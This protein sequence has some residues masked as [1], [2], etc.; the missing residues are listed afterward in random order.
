MILLISKD[1]ENTTRQI[2]ILRALNYEVIHAHY[3]WEV[4]EFYKASNPIKLTLIDIDSVK[5]ASDFI[6]DILDIK[7]IPFIYLTAEIKSSEIE[8]F[9]NNCCYGCIPKDASSFVLGFSISNALSLFKATKALKANEKRYK[10]A[11]LLAGFGHWEMDLN[12]KI[13]FGSEGTE[14]IY[15]V[16][17]GPYQHAE[18]EN[19]VLPEFREK[20]SEAFRNMIQK[21][22]HYDVEFEIKNKK[23][24]NIVSIHSVAE[25]DP[26]SNLVSGSI[27]DISKQKTAEAI[28]KKSGEDY[29]NLFENHHAVM[30]IIDPDTADIVHANLAASKFYGW[31]QNELTSM[32]IT[33]INTLSKKEVYHEMQ[34]A[35]NKGKKYFLFKHRLSNGKV[36]DV[37]VYSGPVTFGGKKRFL[38]IIHD[39]TKRKEAEKA[40][41]RLAYYDP[42]TNLPNRK[43]FIKNL[44]KLISN[45]SKKNSK[46]SLLYIDLDNFKNINDNYG[47]NIGD[48]F[49]KRVVRRLKNALGE[50]S[51]IS[52]LGGDEFTI[53]LEEISDVKELSDIA[54]KILSTLK[55]PFKI[56]NKYNFISASIGISIFPDDGDSLKKLLNN[57]DTVM[58]QAKN[59]GKDCYCFFSEELNQVIKRKDDIKSELR[60]ALKNNELDLYYQ[61]KVDV[62]KNEIVGVEALTRWIRGGHNYLSPDEF[63]PVAEESGLIFEL[64]KWVLITACKQINAWEKSGVKGQKIAVNISALHF[65]Q[66]RI[67]QTVKEV[68][69]QIPVPPKSLEIE[70]TETMFMKDIDEAISILNN[71]RSMGIEISV[72]DFG[73]GYSSLSYLKKLPINKVK[74]DKSFISD[75]TSENGNVVLTQGIIRMAEL[76][77][78]QVIAEGVECK[79]HVDILSEYG[80]HFMQ[81]YYFAKP[82]TVSKYEAFIKNWKI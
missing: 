40:I 28:I 3:Y 30:L 69:N 66:C 9:Q 68:L 14:K 65:K 53:I 44:G 24:G 80:C 50:N 37:E 1:K 2:K 67:L 75:L 60:I 47:H 78:L 52:R 43:M 18:I 15:G 61:P 13:M 20:K 48:L 25:F 12:K 55:Q 58:Y 11:E 8:G 76:L 79:E 26:Q 36:R 74:I 10:K 5:N 46:F 56:N 54:D 16:E 42:L 4:I 33:A 59:D 38:S 82:M 51:N 17:N 22:L 71:L 64:D 6:Q 49:L 31:S 39:V 35:K 77:N 62:S 7:E 19:M 29:R 72:D 57:S 45:T 73:T 34:L 63:I 27:Y 21:G 32:K 81:G 23:N 41:E 70:I